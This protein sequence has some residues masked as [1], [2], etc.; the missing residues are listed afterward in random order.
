MKMLLLDKCLKMTDTEKLI[1]QADMRAKLI[2]K[3][4]GR[5]YP[6]ILLCEIMKINSRIS[7]IRENRI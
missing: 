5:L 3:M 4:V 6:E 1:K 2:T 7:D